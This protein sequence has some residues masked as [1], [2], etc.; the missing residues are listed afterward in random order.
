[1][2]YEVI[3]LEKVKSVTDPSEISYIIMDHTEPDHSGSLA[4]LL[5]IAPQAVVVGSGQA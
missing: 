1:M 2:L 4:R 3:T 5:E